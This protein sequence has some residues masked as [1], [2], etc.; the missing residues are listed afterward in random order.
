MAGQTWRCAGSGQ[1]A[2]LQAPAQQGQRAAARCAAAGAGAAP[3]R[4]AAPAERAAAP[5]WAQCR[6]PPLRHAPPQHA[7][8]RPAKR[9]RC[10][11]RAGA[12]QRPP[13]PG[14]RV[15][16]RA[17]RGRAQAPAAA[18]AAP[19]QPAVE[20]DSAALVSEA[21]K[22]ALARATN[23]MRRVGW[24]SFWSQLTLSV[25]SAGILLFSAAFTS[26]VRSG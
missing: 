2:A 22:K 10:Q 1:C 7:P 20:A 8:G 25:V 19:L 13:R 23:A 6:A 17:G 26:Q 11:V 4:A 15:S 16:V 9:R 3:R 12:G 18:A 24:F 14:G 21:A 5:G